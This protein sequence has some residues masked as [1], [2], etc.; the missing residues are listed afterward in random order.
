M[1]GKYHYLKKALKIFLWTVVSFIGLLSIAL[2]LLVW[3]LSPSQLTPLAQKYANE[4]LDATVSFGRMELTFWKTFPDISVDIDKTQILTH[5]FNKLPAEERTKLPAYQDTLLVMDKFHAGVNVLKLLVGEVEINDVMLDGPQANVVIYSP[6]IAS[7]NIIKPDSTETELPTLNINS[8]EIAHCKKINY[9][10]LP[11]EMSV[12]MAIPAAQFVKQESGKYQFL[13]DAATSL[14]LGDVQ[15]LNNFPI[16]INGTVDWDINNMMKMGIENWKMKFGNVPVTLALGMDLTNSPKI[17]KFNAVIG[18][19]NVTELK[20]YLPDEYLG[21]AKKIE[22]N[23]RGTIKMDLTKP[24]DAQKSAIPSIV[25]TLDIPNSYMVGPNGKRLDSFM[26]ALRTIIDGDNIDN[27]VVELN[28]LILRGESVA[29][30]VNGRATHL[31]SNPKAAGEIL[32]NMNIA[33]AIEIFNLPLDYLVSGSA[34][35]DVKFDMKLGD[36]TKKLYNKIGLNGDL[37]LKNFRVSSRKDNMKAYA[38]NAK[39]YLGSKD[40]FKNPNSSQVND[41]FRASFDID[42]LHFSYNGMTLSAIMSKVGTGGKG[43]VANFGDNKHYIPIGAKIK[44]HR[45]NFMDA[46]SSRVKFTDLLAR[47]SARQ[48]KPNSMQSIINLDIKAG[49]ASYRTP[50]FRTSLTNGEIKMEFEPRERHNKN[51]VDSLRR[52]YPRLS[53]DSLMA[54]ARKSGKRRSHKNDTIQGRE[55]LDLS[56]DNETKGL[57]SRWRLNGAITADK[58]RVVTPY[59]PLKTRL[60]NVN[61]KFSLD[62]FIVNHARFEAGRSSFEISGALRNMRTT[63]MGRNRRPLSAH[64]S[65]FSDTLDINQLM[66]ATFAGINYSDQANKQTFGNSDKY[67]DNTYENKLASD[68]TIAAVIIP[69]N[70]EADIDIFTK[71]GRYTNLNLWDLEGCLMV[72]NGALQLNNFRTNSDAGSLSLNALYGA[73]SKDKIRFAFD[74]GME[75]IGLKRFVTLIPMVDSL[76]PLLKSMDGIIK[77]D[78]AASTDIDSAMNVITPTLTAAVKLHGDSL[79]LFDS[80]TFASISKKLLFKNKKRNLIDNM[81]VE[82]IV[83]DNTLELFPFIFQMDRYKVGIMGTNDLALNLKYHISVLKS[84][85]PFKF[86]LNISGNPDHL[87]FRLGRAKFKEGKV[88]SVSQAFVDNARINLRS[89]IEKAFRRGAHAAAQS[90][91]KLKYM[92]AHDLDEDALTH[93][94]SI[95]MIKAGLIEAPPVVL[96]P[97]QLKEKQKQEKKQQKIKERQRKEAEKEAKKKAKREAALKREEV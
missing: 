35:A 54:L 7:Y 36:I 21:V 17:D 23:C 50:T 94:D 6:T 92:N 76:M 86:G 12:N 27:S 78:I 70:I 37:I 1:M 64:F 28:K 34:K 46:D 90:E 65:I 33:K 41:I 89:Q 5:A 57:L 3:I 56:V 4:Y 10:S 44:S 14:K 53:N 97:K 30:D 2:T 32:C 42:S 83:K 18:E 49:K 55:N 61:V 59:F 51:R 85:I 13:I 29:V 63:M 19:F 38:R 72:N 11:D 84:P 62:S 48:Y 20:K 69:S 9:F 43:N 75:N 16:N 96:T 80:Q 22:T 66:A 82:L 58:A 45:I 52:L 31:I 24:Y 81:T 91:M 73:P 40:K 88:G 87:K 74:L 25:A 93:Q 95:D 60:R 68:T 15:A 79:I 26:M 47:A 67:D 71:Y 8:V 77:A 39:L